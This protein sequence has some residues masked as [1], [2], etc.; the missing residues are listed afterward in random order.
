MFCF[1]SFLPM[2]KVI[3]NLQIGHLLSAMA[4][5]HSLT[6]VDEELAGDPI[7]LKMFQATGWVLALF[8]FKNIFP[9]QVSSY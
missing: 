6:Y 4:T 9:G 5:C 2:Q 8:L 1:L 7:D 3:S